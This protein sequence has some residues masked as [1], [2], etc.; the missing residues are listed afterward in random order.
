MNQSCQNNVLINNTR[1]AWPTYNLMQYLS[2]F[3]SLLPAEYIVF[4]QG[5]HKIE[6][7]HKTC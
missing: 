3:D 1:T 4:Q 6:M 7:E 5:V 2:S